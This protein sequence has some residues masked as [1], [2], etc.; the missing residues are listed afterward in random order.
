MRITANH[1]SIP[2]LCVIMGPLRIGSLVFAAYGFLVPE[3]FYELAIAFACLMFFFSGVIGF[4]LIIFVPAE[5]I[6]DLTNGRRGR[7]FHA[8]LRELT[9]KKKQAPPKV[10]RTYPVPGSY[11]VKM[12]KLISHW[13]GFRQTYLYPA[14]IVGFIVYFMRGYDAW[15][16]FHYPT[17][18]YGFFAYV[19]SFAALGIP[20]FLLFSRRGKR[21]PYCLTPRTKDTFDPEQHVCLRC[22][23]KFVAESENK[24]RSPAPAGS[25]STEPL[26]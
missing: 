19:A 26:P 25:Q 21:C 18:P 23:T 11:L 8:D 3:A 16:D 22:H 2:R 24:P 14:L 5:L 10:V 1:F 13:K 17:M 6:S 4:G 15:F 7:C 9:E 12:E 20:W